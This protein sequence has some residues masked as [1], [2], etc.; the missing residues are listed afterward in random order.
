MKEPTGDEVRG[1]W[2]H[3]L[4]RFRAKRLLKSR[5]LDMAIVARA[6]AVMKILD[7]DRFLSGY[8]T[9]IGRR[10]YTPFDPGVP[11]PQWSLWDQIV[12]CAH[13]MQ[14]VV[15]FG[16]DGVFGYYWPY[17]S[18]SAK[19]SHFEAEAYRSAFELS[20]WRFRALPT[21]HDVAQNLRG[22]SVS[23]VD[24]RVTETMLRMSAFSI[25]RGAVINE[26][27]RAAIDWL[28]D[29]APELSASGA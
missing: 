5:S 2:R 13:E 21:P 8:A 26:A 27:S 14:H 25:G 10:V 4:I 17:L 12:V 23:D 3:M 20:W 9:T 6:L 19:R 28:D 11:H 7:A 29:H 18:S 1:L 24:V 22:Y 16:R 15:Q